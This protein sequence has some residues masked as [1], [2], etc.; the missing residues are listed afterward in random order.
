MA[1]SEFTYSLATDFGGRAVLYELQIMLDANSASP[2]SYINTDGD[3]CRIFTD[4]AQGAL[5]ALVAANPLDGLKVDRYE[6]IDERTE[7]LISQGFIFAGKLFSLSDNAQINILGL[8]QVK[9]DPAMTYPINYGAKDSGDYV[10]LADA[11]AMHG[12][13]LTALGTKRA[14][15]DSGRALKTAIGAATTLAEVDAIVDDR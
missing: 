13:F 9:D 11:A 10:V 14:R 8:E 15:L 4:M 2:G 5:D 7:E 1:I 6:E 12:L 3:V